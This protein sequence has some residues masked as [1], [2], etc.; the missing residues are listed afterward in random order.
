MKINSIALPGQRKKHLISYRHLVVSTCFLL[1]IGVFFNKLNAETPNKRHSIDLKLAYWLNTKSGVSVQSDEY[2]VE[3]DKGGL[4]GKIAYGYYF[5]GDFAL[6][7]SAG[8]LQSRATITGYSVEAST[9][10]PV[11]AG[12]KYYL[13][14]LSN[15]T[16][17]RLYLLGAPGLLI[18]SESD[19]ARTSLNA[20]TETA[21]IIYVGAGIDFILGSV[22]KLT[23]DV[24]YN[25]A[26][27]FSESIAGRK[28]YSGPEIS[29]GFGFTF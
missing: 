26:A 27:D 15:S 22:V 13:T 3:A 2:T 18:G 25:L 19:I 23:A 29:V 9:I 6:Y 10:V 24:G 16:A 8:I 4:S 5:D 12:C 17:A 11:L 28:N 21:F 20:H 1:S 7:V 14:K